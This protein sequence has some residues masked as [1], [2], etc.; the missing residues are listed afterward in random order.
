MQ[1]GFARCS[2]PVPLTYPAPLRFRWRAIQTDPI[3]VSLLDEQRGR[4]GPRRR[5]RSVRY[6]RRET[7][8]AA[9]VD[10]EDGEQAAPGIVS[11]LQN[12]LT[13]QVGLLAQEGLEG[14]DGVIAIIEQ[15][16]KQQEAAFLSR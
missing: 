14:R 16:A 1:R 8:D 3:Q 10:G 6:P 12:L 2:R 11:P 4:A 15:F 5:G 13:G 7:S 9:L